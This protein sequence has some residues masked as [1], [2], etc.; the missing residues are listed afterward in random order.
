MSNKGRVYW[1]T[2]GA[3]RHPNNGGGSAGKSHHG[4]HKVRTSLIVP[5]L[6]CLKGLKD[7]RKENSEEESQEGNTQVTARSMKVRGKGQDLSGTLKR[8]LVA[9]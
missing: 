5:Y 3:E 8:D 7:A 9:R 4:N 2:Q 6:K 1:G